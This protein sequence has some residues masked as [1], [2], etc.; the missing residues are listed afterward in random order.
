MVFFDMPIGWGR[1]SMVTLLN[2][3]FRK[4]SVAFWMI[5]SLIMGAKVRKETKKTKKVSV[6]SYPWFPS[7]PPRVE[8]DLRLG[9]FPAG[10]PGFGPQG[11]WGPGSMRRVGPWIGSV[12]WG[13]SF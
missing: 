3:R 11:P 9:D 7:V 5:F 10:N 13:N 6:V 8:L 1:S 2:P 4:R 12:P